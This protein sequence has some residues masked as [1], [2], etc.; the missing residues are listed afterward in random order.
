MTARSILLP[1]SL[2][3]AALAIAL[4]TGNAPAPAPP[5]ATA[6]SVRSLPMFRPVKF[7]AH[8]RV[9]REGEIERILTEAGVL[10]PGAGPEKVEAARAEFWRAWLERNPTTPAPHKLRRLLE[11]ER[12]ARGRGRALAAAAA[13]P[14]IMSLVVPVEFAGTDTFTY[15]APAPGGGC[16]D[17]QATTSGPLHNATA[18]P[19]PRDNNTLYL[20]DATPA[21]YEELFFASGPEAGVIVDHPN[22][23]A[24]DLR[25]STMA[26]Y[27]LEQSEG[28][29]TPRGSV[30]PKWLAATHSEGWYGS[31][32]CATGSRDVR[33]KNLVREVVDLVNADA[34]AFRWQDYDADSD[35]IVD[36][37]TVIHAGMGQEGGGGA[38]GTFAIWAHASLLNWP[39]GY[40]ACSAGSAGCPARDVYVR[41]YSMD[42]ENIDL[43]AIAEEF[44]HAAFGLPDLYTNDTENSISNWAIMSGGSWNGPLAGTMPAPFPLFFRLLIGW[45]APVEVDY[46]APPTTVKVGQHSL[47]PRGAEPGIQVNLPDRQ[48]TTANAAGTGQGW[49]S[50][51]GD[52]VQ[53]TLT[54]AFGLAGTTAPV[55]SFASSWSIENGW[56]YGYVEISTDGGS[57][58]ATLPDLD[59]R[60][61][62]ADPNGN[63]AGWGLTG[64]GAA[65]LRFDLAAYAGQA[66]LLRLR[67]STDL[68]VQEKGWWADGFA[69]DDG[70]THVFA[71]DVEAGAGAW[72]AQGWELVPRT[73]VYPRYYLVEWRNLSGFDRGLVYPYQTVWSDEDEFEVDRAPYTVPGMLL[74]LRD[75]GYSFDYKLND[76]LTDAPSVGPKHGLLVVDSHPFPYQ[77]SNYHYANG[78]PVRAGSRVQPA[79]ATFT[80]EETTPFTGRLGYDPATGQYVETPLETKTFGP[81]PGVSQFHDSMSYY[82]GY[83]YPGTGGYVYYWHSSSSAVVPAQG[84]YTTRI[85]DLDDMPYMPFYGMGL[86]T[87]VLGSGNPG[88]AGVQLGLHLAVLK[89][90][91]KGRWG[92]IAVWNSAALVRLAIKAKAEIAAG[93]KL[94]Y[95]V[96]VEN[97]T[98][99]PQPFVLE[100]PIP[101][102]TTFASGKGYDAG[103]NGIRY[104]G[105]AKKKK[106]VSFSVLVTDG[107]A[108]GEV[109]VLEAMAKD[110]ALGALGS[111][112]T[113]V[114]AGR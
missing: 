98:P 6:P 56:D 108:V 111:A 8:Y 61:T 19:G 5:A 106:N 1:S 109:I 32:S 79:D 65:T 3:A 24:V 99:A 42:P 12:G 57:T 23:G 81:R 26:N 76:T 50:G 86:G 7:D 51:V 77:W 75:A 78:A 113:T 43:G 83:F 88:D 92:K 105:I 27:Y 20:P 69:I 10:H 18:P 97:L 21:L 40:Q 54:H 41:E 31:D 49:W 90:D 52:L 72:T 71:D 103:T 89:Q 36:N 74:W 91:R 101:P 39:G 66:I 110:G 112:S 96:T 62:N 82:P 46:D 68:S 33:A 44:G 55:F 30:Y 17:Q 28:A 84:N 15:S 2:A 25:G 87:T 48:E 104:E 14:A 85:T 67:Y 16:V 29:F 73:A 94:K 70:A 63:N 37:F 22:L 34:P 93:K 59:G 60:L 64:E 107:T 58:W 38:E 102:H 53:N 13:A 35:G 4:A 100:C 9:P 114:I 80:L 47:R 45:S 11:R 95:T